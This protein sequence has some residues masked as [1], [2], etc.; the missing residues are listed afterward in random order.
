MFEQRSSTSIFARPRF[1]VA[2]R[3]LIALAGGGIFAALSWEAPSD[4][5]KMPVG[6]KIREAKAVRASVEPGARMDRGVA[7]LEPDSTSALVAKRSK[8]D[9][10]AVV[11]VDLPDDGAAPQLRH[12]GDVVTGEAATISDPRSRSP[13]Q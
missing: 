9:L 2:A 1:R 13:P 10:A 4:D 12:A 7:R 5:T 6:G 11:S 3:V 8:E